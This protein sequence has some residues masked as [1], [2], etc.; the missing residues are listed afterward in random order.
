MKFSYILVNIIVILSALLASDKLIYAYGYWWYAVQLIAT[1]LFYYKSKARFLVYLSPSFLSFIYISLS[2]TFGHFVTCNSIGLADIYLTTLR[3]IHRLNLCVGVLLTSN[4]IM[5]LA[6]FPMLRRSKHMDLTVQ[7]L[8]KT[9]SINNYKIIIL[10]GIICALAIVKVKVSDS[11]ASMAAYIF[12]IQL[13]FTMLLLLNLKYL[14]LK[15]RFVVY[16]FLLLLFAIGSYDSKRQIFFILITLIFYE[17]CIN[18]FSFKHIKINFKIVFLTVL[19]GVV[20]LYIILI[21]S[22]LRGYGDYQVH[23]FWQANG[24]I[25]KYIGEDYFTSALVSNLELNSSYVNTINPI[26]YVISGQQPLLYGSTLAKGLFV[27]I[28]SSI[29]QKPRS[30]VDIYTSIYSPNFRM[31]GGS[32]PVT[33]PA[34]LFWNFHVFSFPILAFMYLIFNKYYLVLVNGLIKNRT[35]I[36]FIMMFYLYASLMQIA[37]GSGLDLWFAYCLI[38]LPFIVMFRR[39]FKPKFYRQRMPVM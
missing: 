38:A 4:F 18:G 15:P 36:G 30:I 5:V 37:R 31:H 20:F 12:P 1:L 7:P 9:G 34:E 39:I 17:A 22:I 3:N 14:T 10:L 21:S 19:L 27:F 13:G 35:T 11:N 28:P 16:G 25:F 2:A 32:L 33:I 6:S 8:R 23:G 26:N 24:F 29:V